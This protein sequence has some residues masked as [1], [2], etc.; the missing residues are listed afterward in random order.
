ME[1]RKHTVRNTAPGP[2]GLNTVD[3]YR[4]LAPGETLTGVELSE[5]EFK[6]ADKT[7]YFHFD[8]AAKR[9]AKA[10]EAPG[11]GEGLPNN[12]PKLKGIAKAEGVD[13]SG[14]NSVADIQKAILDARTAKAAAAATPPAPPTDDLDNMSD[15]DLR[16]T[17]Q[18]ITGDEPA[19]DADRETLLK[20]ARGQE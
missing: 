1:I 3:G 17:V 18:A 8:S 15:A 11:S 9:D 5:A 4:E 19:A 16:S 6:S 12:M 20:L 14:L 2:R 10:D 7:G 13:I